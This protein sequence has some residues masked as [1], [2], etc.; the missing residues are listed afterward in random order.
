MYF[1]H[2]A[3]VASLLFAT[4]ASAHIV[5]GNEPP[6]QKTR[7][8]IVHGTVVDSSGKPVEGVTVQ[9]NRYEGGPL[10]PQ[11]PPPSKTNKA[12]KFEINLQFKGTESAILKEIWAEK[13]GYI[14]AMEVRRP[15]IKPGDKLR[16]QFQLEPGF[17]LAGSVVMNASV[18]Q[19]QRRYFLRIVGKRFDQVHV[20][21]P[22]G[23]FEIYVPQGAYSIAVLGR[24]PGSEIK[25][26][27]IKAGTRGVQLKPDAATS[28]G[29]PK[30]VVVTESL[31][32][33][34]FD[35]LWNRMDAN[36]SYFAYK[37]D[38]DWQQIGKKYRA[39]AIKAKSVDEFVEVLRSMLSELKDMHVWIKTDRKT[40]G[41]YQSPWQRNWNPKS[42]FQ[43]LER[44]TK[45]GD[46]AFVGRT[47]VDGFGYVVINKQSVATEESVQM[48]VD[49][50][51]K[52]QDAPGFIVDLRG[53]CNG[54]SELFAR[55]IAEAFCDKQTVYAKHK[56][57]NGPRHDEFGTV[58]Q[59]MIQ[60]SKKPYTK[61]VVC[62]IGNKCMSS[63]EALVLMM[64]SLP[65]VTTIGMRT[66]GASGNP[67][68]FPLPKLGVD[69]WYSRWVALEP[70][71]T[72]FEGT[73]IAPEIEVNAPVKDYAQDDPTLKQAIRV[74][75]MK[76][77]RRHPARR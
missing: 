10:K 38:V 19:P 66:R 39:R 46:F 20:T 3:V 37:P 69:V 21:N 16:L 28:S 76:S 43:M 27:G 50:I 7:Q 62:L 12:G 42:I 23:K 9:I 68:R 34:A 63:G 32:S 22:G 58:N 70:D 74:L 18:R 57:R 59:R 64:K 55:R 17:V 73:G 75:R 29:S 51:A 56:Y 48:T 31:L 40:I 36:Y 45:C 67:I 35:A 52:L 13:S 54:G 8:A 44:P 2:R 5:L 24:P 53:G 72:P 71:E 47:A 30:Q 11:S 41:T 49:E 6:G 60:P 15:S 1:F 65:H 77:V 33:D 4:F 61:P 14:R 25:V 26:A